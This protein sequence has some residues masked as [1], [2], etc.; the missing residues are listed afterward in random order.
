MKEVLSK[1]LLDEIVQRLSKSLFYWE[2][3]QEGRELE[4]GPERRAL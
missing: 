4:G 2:I 3:L 1:E